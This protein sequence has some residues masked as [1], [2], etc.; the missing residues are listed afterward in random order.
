MR[1]KSEERVDIRPFKERLRRK[2][3]PESSVLTDLLSEPDSMPVSTAEVL[4][5]HYLR[6]LERELESRG[7]SPSLV[8]RA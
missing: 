4:I 5:P 8:M 2:L 6:R 1:L 3:P 7:R